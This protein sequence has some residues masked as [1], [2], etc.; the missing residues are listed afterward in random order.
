METNAIF[1]MGTNPRESVARQG[2][3]VCLRGTTGGIARISSNMESAMWIKIADFGMAISHQASGGEG[4]FR[5]VITLGIQ[6]R[7]NMRH[8]SRRWKMRSLLISTN[9]IERR[10]T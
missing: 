2:A 5:G 9:V 10:T 8:M 3:V 4:I 6:T 7:E 1:G